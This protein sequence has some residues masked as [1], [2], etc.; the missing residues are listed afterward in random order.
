MRRKMN[1]PEP[2]RF[3]L[4]E[5]LVVIA[6]IAILAGILMPALS[7]A[8]QTAL[9]SSCLNNMKAI[10]NACQTYQANYSDWILPARVYSK[11]WYNNVYSDI[12]ADT[13]KQLTTCPAEAI[14]SQ[15]TS[16]DAYVY[17]H[18]GLNGNLCGVNPEN[19]SPGVPTSNDE[20]K[21]ARYMTFRKASVVFS[22][23]RALLATENKKKNTYMLTSSQGAFAQAFRHGGNYNPEIGVA[24]PTA[25]SGTMINCGYFDGHAATESRSIFEVY[26]SSN[27]TVFFEGWR[28]KFNL[29]NP[30]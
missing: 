26:L 3:T 7:K 14:P 17:G 6:I 28:D 21:Q 10:L 24:A 29:V 4:I 20:I 9:R 16:P 18:Y 30:L 25:V 8:R 27:M 12:S 13:L 22:A 19:R 1:S 5:L 15:G 11:I 2:R 23:S